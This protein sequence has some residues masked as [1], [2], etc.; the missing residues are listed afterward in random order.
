MAKDSQRVAEELMEAGLITEE[1]MGKTLEYAQSLGGSVGQIVMRLGFADEG[2]VFAFMLKK[3]RLPTVDLSG[4]VIPTELVRNVPW[5]L[6]KKHEVLPFH[7]DRRTLSL[8]IADP[9]DISVIEEIQFQIG[10]QV[11]LHLAKRSDI[12]AAA[13]D[14]HGEMVKRAEEDKK[15]LSQGKLRPASHATLQALQTTTEG[16]LVENLRTRSEGKLSTQ[17]LSKGDMREAL[18]PALLKKG[19][20]TRSELFD[21]VCELLVKKEVIDQAEMRE[22]LAKQNQA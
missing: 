8:A 6:I 12:I 16:A 7:K 22:I 20:I 10:M 5:E 14:Y 1:Q 15:S 21:A 17:N 19:V 2:K 11:E 4:M 18:I 3:Y 9:S 13:K